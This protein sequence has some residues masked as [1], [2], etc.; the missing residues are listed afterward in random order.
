[1]IEWIL[2]ILV[3]TAEE[4]TLRGKKKVAFRTLVTRFLDQRL[5]RHG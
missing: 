5:Q 3:A 2:V 4:V 1:M